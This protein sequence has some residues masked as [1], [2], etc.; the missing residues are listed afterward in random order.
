MPYIFCSNFDVTQTAKVSIF[1][2]LKEDIG[3]KGIIRN[4]SLTFIAWKN[5][6]E[7]CQFEA[8]KYMY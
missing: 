1:K 4:S 7:F 5:L 8:G 2:T 6:V 3:M